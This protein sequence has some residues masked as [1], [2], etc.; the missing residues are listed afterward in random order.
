[1]VFTNKMLPASGTSLNTNW[2]ISNHVDSN[3]VSPKY[4][5]MDIRF[6]EV[7]KNKIVLE[8]QF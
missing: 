5:Y 2:F 4:S 6:L 1:M 7:Y 8:S 3:Q